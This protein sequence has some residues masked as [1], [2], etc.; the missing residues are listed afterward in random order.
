MDSAVKKVPYP[1][2]DGRR[3]YM[4][5]YMRR[6]RARMKPVED[7]AIDDDNGQAGVSH[8]DPIQDGEVG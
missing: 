2:T 4:R 3:D 1:N 6:Y 8:P 5:E 7:A